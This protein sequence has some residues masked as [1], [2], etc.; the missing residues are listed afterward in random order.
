VRPQPDVIR[1]GQP[2]PQVI[3]EIDVKHVCLVP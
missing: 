2:D 1:G 3:E